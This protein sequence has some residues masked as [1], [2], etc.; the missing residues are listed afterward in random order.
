MSEGLSVASDASGKAIVF[1]P[2]A[3][4]GSKARRAVKTVQ[5]IGEAQV[6]CQIRVAQADVGMGW[7]KLV[8]ALRMTYEVDCG[9]WCHA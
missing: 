8:I 2:R 5:R 9:V 1:I 7:R 3:I 4:S 6:G